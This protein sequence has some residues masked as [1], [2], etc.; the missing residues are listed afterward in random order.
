VEGAILHAAPLGLFE[1]VAA[2]IAAVG[3]SLSRPPAAVGELA[4]ECGQEALGIGG[5]AS[6][7]NDVEDQAALAVDEVELVSALH[8]M[9][10]LTMMSAFGS[11]R[12]TSFS[13]AGTASPWSIRRSLWP[14]ME[15]DQRQ[16][17]IDRGAPPLG[18]HLEDLGHASGDRPQLGARRL[19][20][21]DQFAI[22]LTFLVLAAAVVDGLRPLLG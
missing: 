17:M 5:V 4:I 2:G 22:E 8:G 7:D 15:D 16:I 18:R 10:P 14:M 9:A 12:L 19:S 1:I 20:S 11:N 13:P 21:D 6:F 3:G